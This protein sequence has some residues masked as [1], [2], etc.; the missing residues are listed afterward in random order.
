MDFSGH[1]NCVPGSSDGPIGLAR[2][3]NWIKDSLVFTTIFLAL[4]LFNP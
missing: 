2:D 1:L 4:N 3:Q